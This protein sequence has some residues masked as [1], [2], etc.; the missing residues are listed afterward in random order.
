MFKFVLVTLCSM[1]PLLVVAGVRPVIIVPGTGGSQL[2]AKLNKPSVKH[3][4]C[5]KTSD[6]YTIWLSVTQLLPP[7]INC[8]V[9][10]IRLLFN[11]TD[12]T[13]SNNVGVET[14]TP[15][16][17]T[18]E[19]IEYLDPSLK[20]GDSEYFFALVDA[21]VK[22]GGVRNHSIRGAAYDFRRSADSAYDGKYVEML[23]ALVE[24]TFTIN[25]NEKVTLLS[26]S[27]GCLYSLYFLNQMFQAWKDKYIHQWIP[28]SGVFA[29][30]GEGVLQIV[31][32]S[33]EGIPGVSGLTV[34]GEQRSYQSSLWLLPTS[35][36]FQGVPLAITPSRN[37]T[38]DDYDALFTR[39]KFPTGTE[40]LS[41]VANL[42]TALAAPN[43]A[44][45]HLY[46]L[47]VKTATQFRW[48]KDSDFPDTPPTAIN[49]DGDGTVPS[50]SLK[51]VEKWNVQMPGNFS[52]RVFA[53]QCHTCV[54][55][56]Q[57][58]INEVLSLLKV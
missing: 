27:M 31:S 30:A 26:H 52:S 20:A 37:Y 41:L 11:E 23:Q 47:G 6:W 28:T 32:G 45:R 51:S 8:W 14:R 7:A 29:G 3:F 21:L 33:N 40:R 57:D 24:E 9:D 13:Y 5:S 39:A 25:G 17:G 53:G 55:K 36:T 38:V 12:K 42:T 54:V 19:A 35:P 49:G 58:Y 44:T 18:T 15:G 16:W 22:N 4:Y 1:L 2:Q 34:R 50:A 48:D 43:V 10:N 46:G 56:N